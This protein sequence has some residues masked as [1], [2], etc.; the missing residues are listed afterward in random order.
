[1]AGVDPRKKA[2]VADVIHRLHGGLGVEEAR[3][4]IARKVGSITSSEIT[5]IEQSLI[6]EGVSPDEIRRFCNVHALLFESSLEQSVASPE[7]P[8]HPVNALRRENRRIEEL[9][10]AARTALVDGDAQLLRSRLEVLQ[11]VE[12]HYAIKE[13]A[14]FPFLEK[15]GFPGP[16]KVMW[17]KHDEVRGL[18]K[19]VAGAPTP[20]RQSVE[21]LLAEVE[22]MI[23]KE[24]SILFPAALERLTKSEWVQVLGACTEIGFPFLAEDALHGALAAAGEVTAPTPVTPHADTEEIVMP[25]GRLSPTELTSLLDTLPVDITF[26]DADDKVKYFSQSKDR[27][28]V[29]ATSVIG[30]DVK[31]CH[32]PQSVHK[33]EKIVRDFKDGT[34]D[35]ADFWIELNGKL[36]YI[37]YFAVRDHSGRFLGTLEVTQDLT[38]IRQISG[39][40]RLLDD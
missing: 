11:G 40:R 24:E 17:S 26:V 15:H 23:F 39:E 2:V 21:S 13:N 25:S 6:D 33:V 28:F 10:G 5:E 38:E 4:E 19:R 7:S 16:S 14:L 18:L 35:H 37:R 36:I 34:R 32:P 3:E 20:D 30:R 1:M 8:T 9:V 22:G 29:R 27:I 12:R 31:N